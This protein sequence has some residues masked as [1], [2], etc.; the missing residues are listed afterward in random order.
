MNKK[1]FV[2]VNIVKSVVEKYELIE[3]IVKL[4][5]IDVNLNFLY[6]MYI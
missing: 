4:K 6:F 2:I 3:E 5:G 1:V